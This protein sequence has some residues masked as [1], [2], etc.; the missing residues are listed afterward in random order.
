MGMVKLKKEGDVQKDLL[1]PEKVME[2]LYDEGCEV[3]AEQSKLILDFL[4][5]MAN[6]VVL[7]YLKR[8]TEHLED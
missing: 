5:K 7:N 1:T 4:R 8:Q 6:I 3:T 2:M